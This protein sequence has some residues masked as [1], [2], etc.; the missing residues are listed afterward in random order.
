MEAVAKIKTLSLLDI[1]PHL[2][3]RPTHRS[4][5]KKYTA[6]RLYANYDVLTDRN[7]A[8]G[9]TECTN[10]VYG[11]FNGIRSSGS[12][13]LNYRI[14]RNNVVQSSSSLISDT[15]GHFTE[16]IEENHK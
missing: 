9:S 2:L 14:I 10:V 13:A 1:E 16:R 5:Y 12:K 7:N 8:V 3:G 4:L 11:P 6:L 15:C